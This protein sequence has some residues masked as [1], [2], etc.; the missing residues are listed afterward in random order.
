LTEDEEKKLQKAIYWGRAA[1]GI[2]WGTL[3]AAF[4]RPYLGGLLTAA[5][6]SIFAYLATYLIV[7]NLLGKHR[8]E[9]I[10]GKNKLYTIGIGVFFLSVVFAWILLYSLFF[11]SW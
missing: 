7:A 4:W 2:G 9:L 5:S 11:H 1:V 3:L 8:V 6:M 10:G